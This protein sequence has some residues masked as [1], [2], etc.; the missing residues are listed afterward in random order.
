[1]GSARLLIKRFPSWSRR[2]SKPLRLGSE[3]ATLVPHFVVGGCNEL[4]QRRKHGCV[5]DSKS[6]LHAGVARNAWLALLAVVG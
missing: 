3:V 6:G 5:S 4:E 1:M 2:V